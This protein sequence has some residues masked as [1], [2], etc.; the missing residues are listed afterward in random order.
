MAFKTKPKNKLHRYWMNQV[1]DKNLGASIR[2]YYR[3]LL[4]E[5]GYKEY[6]VE[7]D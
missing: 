3:K 4:V 1:D 6:E 2:E 5:A 7:S